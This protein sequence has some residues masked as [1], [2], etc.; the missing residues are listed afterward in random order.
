MNKKK[1]GYI[2]EYWGLRL[3][4]MIIRLLSRKTALAIGA[5]IGYIIYIL[6]IRKR[7]SMMNLKRVF[8]ETKSEKELENILR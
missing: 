8:G 6:G 7:V 5:F 3:F 2:L 1:I 4:V